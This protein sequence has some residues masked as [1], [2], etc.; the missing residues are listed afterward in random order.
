MLIKKLSQYL[1]CLFLTI[2]QLMS[3]ILSRSGQLD[4]EESCQIRKKAAIIL[5][6]VCSG[7]LYN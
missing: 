2:I 7:S 1:L 6:K 3:N 4:F 5:K